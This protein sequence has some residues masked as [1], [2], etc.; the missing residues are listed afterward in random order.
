MPDTIPIQVD[1]REALAT[2]SRLRGELTARERI[3]RVAAFSGAN[4]VR[5]HLVARN[6]RSGRSNYWSQA[7]E[8]TT[9]E[10]SA[11]AAAVV[12][13][14][15]GVGWHRWGGTIDAKPGKA[16]AIPLRGDV[17][18][19][20]WPSERFGPRPNAAFV[21]RRN[22]KA[23]L[24][25]RDGKALRILYLLVKSVSKAEDPSVLP[26]HAEIATAVSASIRS[27]VYRLRRQSQT[28]EI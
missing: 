13:R 5:R 14:H 2:L 25:I 20:E 10:S 9:P 21:W 23:F 22:G 28:S 26:T 12:I 24:A 19:G 16:M 11:A 1:A 15:P 4:L 18:N 3:N 6:D 7:A 8:A 27:L 17:T